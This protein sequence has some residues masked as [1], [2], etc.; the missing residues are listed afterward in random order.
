MTNPQQAQKL[1][2]QRLVL[3]FTAYQRGEDVS[4]AQL[5]RAEGVVEACC[6]LGLTT[7]DQA[8]RLMDDTYQQVFNQPP[9]PMYKNL[10]YKNSG[11][12]QEGDK[13]G[14]AFKIPALMK[15]APVYPST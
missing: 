7:Q 9:P 12:K 10:G 1:I 5:Y 15:R 4:P 2:K 6:D 8:L 11:Y 13:K 14:L 3:I